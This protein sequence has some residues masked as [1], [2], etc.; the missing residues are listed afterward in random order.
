[1][2]MAFFD[3]KWAVVFLVFAGVIVLLYLLGHKTVHTELVIPADSK[4]IWSVLTD[5]PKYE[6]WNPIMVKVQG[7]LREGKK[8]INQFRQA[9]GKEYEV[10]STVRKMVP[11]ELLNQC[12][13]IPGVLTFDHKYVLKPVEGGTRVIQHEEYR[14]IGVLFWDASSMKSTYEKANEALM[15]RV[16]ELINKGSSFR[17][18]KP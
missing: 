1:M 5:T 2:N 12:G 18:P 8:L 6:E 3:S 17:Q 16:T 10:K 9:D 15:N 4:I 11:N 14:G 13:G 7:E